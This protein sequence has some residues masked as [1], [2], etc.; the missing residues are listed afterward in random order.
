MFNKELRI[1]RLIGWNIKTK[2]IFSYCDKVKKEE[3]AIWFHCYS[4]LIGKRVLSDSVGGMKKKKGESDWLIHSVEH[5]DQQQTM[6]KKKFFLWLKQQDQTFFFFGRHHFFI[7]IIVGERPR[8]LNH[9]HIFD[10]GP[11]CLR[12]KLSSSKMPS[13]TTTQTTT[14]MTRRISNMYD[15]RQM[16]IGR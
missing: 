11:F 15:C 13:P 5:D 9:P 10:F 8:N 16:I 7:I 2:D 1:D 4:I 14:T 12:K 3:K 6:T